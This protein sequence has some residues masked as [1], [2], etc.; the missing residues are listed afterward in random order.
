MAGS[1]A[2]EADS[3]FDTDNVALAIGA[4]FHF[5][6]AIGQRFRADNDLPW[7]ADQIGGCE[8]AAGTGIGVII[9]HVDIAGFERT[10]DGLAGRIGGLVA[11][12]QIDQADV[13]RRDFNRPGNALIIWTG[14]STP[15]G[16][17]TLAPNGSE[18]LVPK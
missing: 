3:L 12:F 2:H 13:E 5:D 10:V 18:Y 15:S 4:A 7:Q 6:L 8:F 17:V 9:Q 16:P 1:T 14:R 11:D